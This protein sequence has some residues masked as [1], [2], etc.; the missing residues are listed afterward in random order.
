MSLRRFA[1]VAL[2]AALGLVP[3][4]LTSAAQSAGAAPPSSARA[5]LTTAEF[6]SQMLTLIN[7]RR[8]SVGCPKFTRVGALVIAARKHSALMAK[9][10]Q[11]SHRFPGEPS[12]GTRISQAGYTNWKAVAENVGFA[13]NTSSP[14]TI[15]TAWVRSSGHRANLD[16]CS[17]RAAGV[18][19]VFNARGAWVT[20]DLGRR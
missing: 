11:L 2:T 8:T 20:L 12:L 4:A 10:N 7:N 14:S 19:V 3:L 15:F 1:A 9:N 5:A 16:N 18:G 13:S 6:E 17:L